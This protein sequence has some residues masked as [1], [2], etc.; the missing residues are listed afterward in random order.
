MSHG[1]KVQS[2]TDIITNSSSE[3]FL[4]N[5][6]EGQEITGERIKKSIIEHAIEHRCPYEPWWIEE[7]KN[8]KELDFYNKSNHGD[9]SGE[10]RVMSL[11]DIYLMYVWN[12]RIHGHTP[13]FSNRTNKPW[14]QITID[15]VLDS[16]KEDIEYQQ[17][18]HPFI[19]DSVLVDI[20]HELDKTWQA[21][22]DHYSVE[23]VSGKFPSWIDFMDRSLF[24]WNLERYRGT[25]EDDRF[26]ETYDYCKKKFNQWEIGN[27]ILC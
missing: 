12:T 21:M 5:P 13:S 7:H 25:S 6:R 27:T 14:R 4:V 20:D 16:I 24:D 9:V 3:T 18:Y 23:E 2:I 26:E 19:K 15:E 1:I 17:I 8:D 11:F 10:L 22:F